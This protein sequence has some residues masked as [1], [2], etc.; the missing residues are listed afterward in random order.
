[1]MIEELLADHLT[2]GVSWQ[3]APPWMRESAQ[4]IVATMGTGDVSSARSQFLAV[5][6]QLAELNPECTAV[7][8]G[9]LELSAAAVTPRGG[10][11]QAWGE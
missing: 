5:L 9:A 11:P 1:M 2:H 6:R 7:I 8:V 10:W 3:V 4:E